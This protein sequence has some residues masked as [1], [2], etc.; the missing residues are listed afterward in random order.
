MLSAI[1]NYTHLWLY[2]DDAVIFI[3]VKQAEMILDQ[4]TDQVD[5]NRK[6]K[7]LRIS[8][9][10]DTAL[11]SNQV[12]AL[13]QSMLN[14]SPSEY[15]RRNELTKQLSR[16]FRKI[17]SHRFDDAIK[18]SQ[19]IIQELDELGDSLDVL[20]GLHL[21]GLAHSGVVSYKQPRKGV[22]SDDENESAIRCNDR[23]ITLATQLGYL[24]YAVDAMYNKSL[25]M[26][27]L[28][29]YTS[30]DVQSMLANGVTIAGE[31]LVYGPDYIRNDNW[32]LPLLISATK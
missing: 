5:P 12:H 3:L 8:K 20:I 13:I 30:E 18:Q 2:S 16:L 6:E 1:E 24:D 14:W 26:A 25:H 11:G 29:R 15:K 31:R 21:Q 19:S 7:L 4:R 28:D 32:N 10:V 17:P 22:S 9:E 27:H 23:A